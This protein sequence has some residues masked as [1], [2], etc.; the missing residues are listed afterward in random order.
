MV[1]KVVLVCLLFVSLA[2]NDASTSSKDLTRSLAQKLIQ[3]SEDFKARNGLEVLITKEEAQEGVSRGLWKIVEHP[4]QNAVMPG[5][6][7]Q[8]LTVKGQQ[9]FIS[10]GTEASMR[11][12][13]E[14]GFAPGSG[15]FDLKLG[16]SAGP[17]VVE[18]TGITG[19]SEN[20]KKAKFTWD[21]NLD[22]LPSD[23]RSVFKNSVKPGLAN[24]QLYDDGWRVGTVYEGTLP[25]D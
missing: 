24:F 4:A 25:P 3:S 8:S 16:A 18:I 14:Q 15:F 2:C 9:Y 6:T 13:M 10:I 21:W 5:Y 23:V 19:D 1:R 7:E 20:K 17:R 22:N 11:A 12:A